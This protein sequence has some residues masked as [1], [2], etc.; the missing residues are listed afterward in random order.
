MLCRPSGSTQQ[1]SSKSG[2]IVSSQIYL[3]DCTEIILQLQ[4]SEL[5]LLQGIAVPCG[6]T[7]ESRL[8][9]ASLIW[10]C[11]I[12]QSGH[13]FERPGDVRRLLVGS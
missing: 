10:G 7:R 6:L 12:T 9:L 5:V 8:T 11:G 2:T 3:R 13:G 4:G 1:A